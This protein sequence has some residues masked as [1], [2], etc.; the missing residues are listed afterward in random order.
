MK[1][2]LC[3]RRFES[4]SL[5]RAGSTERATEPVS[6]RNM[7]ARFAKLLSVAIHARGKGATWELL[8]GCRTCIEARSRQRYCRLHAA[9]S[10]ASTTPPRSSRVTAAAAG[11]SRAPHPPP[12]T[13]DWKKRQARPARHRSRVTE[14]RRAGRKSVEPAV[15][16]KPAEAPARRAEAAE[17]LAKV[18][19]ALAEAPTMLGAAVEQPSVHPPRSGVSGTDLNPAQAARGKTVGPNAR[20]SAA[21]ELAIARRAVV[22]TP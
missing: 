15:A 22:Q 4:K 14:A 19:V 21:T 5:P 13:Q 18:K 6:T 9:P 8:G 17:G 1:P 20:G 3:G 10:S 2:L 16:T 7:A 11:A 12:A